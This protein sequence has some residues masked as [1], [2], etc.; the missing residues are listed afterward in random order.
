LPVNTIIEAINKI[1][2]ITYYQRSCIVKNY[3][4]EFQ[5]LILEA[6]YVDLCTIIVKFHCSLQLAIQN[7]I[8]TLPVKRLNNTDSST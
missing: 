3:L 8:A 2:G 1:E 4:Y 7:Q 5:S 6:N